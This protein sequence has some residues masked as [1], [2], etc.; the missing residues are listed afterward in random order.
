MADEATLNYLAEKQK[1]WDIRDKL[2]DPNEYMDI[3][4]TLVAMAKHIDFSPIFYPSGSR[5]CTVYFANGGFIKSETHELTLAIEFVIEKN[6]QW[7]PDSYK[8]NLGVFLH[9]KFYPEITNE[10]PWLVR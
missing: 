8:L 10:V 1:D 9:K 3:A 6:P 5:P 4:K 7:L 2:I